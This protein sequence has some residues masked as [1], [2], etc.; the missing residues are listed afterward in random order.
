LAVKLEALAASRN[1]RPAWIPAGARE[2]N[3]LTWLAKM[4]YYLILGLPADV[5]RAVFGKNC[6]RNWW[7]SHYR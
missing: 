6:V 7:D 4:S 1:L 3:M 5:L 2:D